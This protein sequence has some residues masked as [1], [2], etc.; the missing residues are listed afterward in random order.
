MQHE[1]QGRQR[2]SSNPDRTVLSMKKEEIYKKI[3]DLWERYRLSGKKKLW[4]I[5]IAGWKEQG[6][7][8]NELIREHKKEFA[9][10]LKEYGLINLNGLTPREQKV[11]EMRFLEF[12]S[13]EETSKEFRVTRERIWQLEAKAIGKLIAAKTV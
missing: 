2:I 1:T 4:K 3:E 8:I 7:L 12:N 6:L 10:T 9:Q 11:L 5:D 13:L